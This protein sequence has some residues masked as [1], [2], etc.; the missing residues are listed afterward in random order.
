[1]SNNP[2]NVMTPILRAVEPFAGIE[3]RGMLFILSSPSGAGK[4][5]LSRQLMAADDN[6]AMSVSATT[7]APRPNEVDGVDYHFVSR[8]RFDAMVAQGE[9]LEHATVFDN[10]YGSPRAPVEKALAE[11]RD[12][13][14]DVD[15]QGAQQIKIAMKSDVVSVFILPP[16]LEALETR[17]KSRAQDD[18]A[19]VARRMSKALDEI[20]HWREYKYVLV[21]ENL[22]KCGTQLAAVLSAERLK[23]TRRAAGLEAFV[24]GLETAKS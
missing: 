17:L 5:T 21:N 23:L 12:V 19:T 8:E 13:L 9:M 14:F 10:S 3:R 18:D 1:M 4:T 11:G 6:I 24:T 2:A 22:E 16:S 7:R 20:S 15:W